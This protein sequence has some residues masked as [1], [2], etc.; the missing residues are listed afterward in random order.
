M[1]SI[2]NFLSGLLSANGTST[3]LRDYQHASRLYVD[4]L[5]AHAPKFG[6][7]YYVQLN[8]NP[9]LGLTFNGSQDVGLLA[10]SCDL[11]KFTIATETANQYNRKTVVQTKLT[12]TPIEIRLHDDNSNLTHNLWLSYFKHYYADSTYGDFS[13]N[14]NQKETPS[15]FGDTKYGT[16]DYWYGLGTKPN[17]DSI[18][19][20]TS[21][22]IF[23][24]NQHKF[25]QYTL[26]NPKITSWSHDTVDYEGSK[27]LSNKMQVAYE[28]VTY[29]TGEIVKGVSPEGWS[30]RYYDNVTSPIGDGGGQSPTLFSKLFGT[31]PIAN[32]GST[33]LKNYVN[34]N[35]AG[36]ASSTVYNIA[37]GALGALG[38]GGSGAPQSSQNQ[39]GVITSPGGVGINIFKAANTTVDGKIRANPAA[40][41]FPKG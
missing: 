37:G 26:I 19:F 22:D 29:K 41:I 21:I 14:G 3:T 32:I 15:Q 13:T 36:R 25:T 24:L 7:L 17:N 31:G 1:P 28:T 5:Y 38:A 2:T 39:P 4:S 40:I 16:T 33:L 11:P 6:F 9:Q 30:T 20:L 12:Y 8:F 35:G 34:K 18:E 23:V 27:T 10:K